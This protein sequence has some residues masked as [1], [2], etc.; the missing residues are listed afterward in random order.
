MKR[1][2][3]T[4]IVCSFIALFLM[5]VIV[6]AQGNRASI[7]GTVFDSSG[8]VVVGAHIVARNVDTGIETPTVSNDRGIYLV[9]NLPP[10]T[11]SVFVR[12]E[13]FKQVEFTHI[14]LILDQVAELNATMAAGAAVEAVTVTGGAP[15]L[16]TETSTIGTNMN[17]NVV[18]DLPLNVYGGRQAEYF[19]VA[20]TPGYSPLSDPYLAVINGQPRLHKRLHGRWHFR[21]RQPAGR[22]F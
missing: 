5:P 18:T 20:L 13:G 12:K 7:T 22:Y 9:P 17:G 4:L 15:V 21:H 2:L 14:T 8:A 19:A 11:Y 10:G 6:F 16:E 3:L 1:L